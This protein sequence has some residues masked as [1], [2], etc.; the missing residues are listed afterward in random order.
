MAGSV[1]EKVVLGVGNVLRRD[2]GV[3][4]HAVRELARH[5]CA[6]QADLM[7]GGT[8]VFDA[9]SGWETIEKLVVIDALQAGAAPG[10]ITRLTAEQVADAVSP[11]LSLHQCG[12]IDA[13]TQLQQA[14]LRLGEVVIYGVEPGDTGWGE[15]LSPAVA[16]SLSRLTRQV[17]EDIEFAGVE[18]MAK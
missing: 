2:E 11:A 14:G 5:G 4:V 16:A 9:L 3:G 7:D 1:S 15:Q 17:E 13:L 6:V 18:E 12:L 10:T 8:A